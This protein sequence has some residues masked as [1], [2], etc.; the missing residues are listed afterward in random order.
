MMT[1]YHSRAAFPGAEARRRPQ[2][3]YLAAMLAK[4]W[5]FRTVA[6]LPTGSVIV[7]RADA[8][9]GIH[10]GWSIC[11]NGGE[12]NVERINDSESM[13]SVPYQQ[14]GGLVP[15]GRLA[16]FCAKVLHEEA[17]E[18]YGRNEAVDG[19]TIDSV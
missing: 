19:I 5:G 17:I 14:S 1:G 10:E 13:R 3:P 2:L 8:G 4:W 15:V 9:R 11:D 7:E 16:W 12:L 6:T 18:S